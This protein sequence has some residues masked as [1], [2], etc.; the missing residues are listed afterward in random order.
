MTAPHGN[1]PDSSGTTSGTES[2]RH[3]RGDTPTSGTT[4]GANVHDRMTGVHDR[5]VEQR[6]IPARTKPAKTSAAA[7][8]GLVFGLS[9]L[10]CALTA[11]L[12]PLAVL[13]GLTG[14]VLGIVGMKKAKLV[15]VTGKG[16]ALGGLLTA[17]LGLLLGGAV[18]AGAAFLVNSPAGLDRVQSE[19]DKLRNNLPSTGEVR[20]ELPAG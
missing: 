7:A 15:G 11:I 12:A 8:F 18:L 19:L 17:V 13:F 2:G 10:F 3:G 20:S 14:L 4:A 1:T 6:V 9:A 5:D 16:V